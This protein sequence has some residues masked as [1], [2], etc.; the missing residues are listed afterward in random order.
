[1]ENGIPARFKRSRQVG[2]LPDNYTGKNRAVEKLVPLRKFWLRQTIKC[3]TGALAGR[4]QAFWLNKIVSMVTP[5][6]PPEWG[7][8]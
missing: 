1:M 3:G 8:A 6:L 5:I 4:R 2:T 7:K